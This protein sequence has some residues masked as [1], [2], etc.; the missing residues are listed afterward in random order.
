MATPLLPAVPDRLNKAEYTKR[1]IEAK[2]GISDVTIPSVAP[3]GVASGG[4]YV[5]V[6]AIDLLPMKRYQNPDGCVALEAVAHVVINYS[7]L[8]IRMFAGSLSCSLPSV[9]YVVLSGAGVHVP[10]GFS[11]F[12]AIGVTK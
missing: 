12:Q 2:R 6:F 10:P 8:P 1:S 9:P 11:S 5:D 3:V 4:G 7:G